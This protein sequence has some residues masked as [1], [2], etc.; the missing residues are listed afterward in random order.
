MGKTHR[1]LPLTGPRSSRRVRPVEVHPAT[2]A[3]GISPFP[4]AAELRD[5]VRWCQPVARQAEAEDERSAPVLADWRPR[6]ERNLPGTWH[7]A[8]A[9]SCFNLG[10]SDPFYIP[11]QRPGEFQ[12]PC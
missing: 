8:V 5:L 10:H 2:P 6:D 9:I 4:R 11:E 12:L 3:N 1:F 7:K